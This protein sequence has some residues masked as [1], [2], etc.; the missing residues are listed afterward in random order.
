MIAYPAISVGVWQIILSRS[1]ISMR[2]DCLVLQVVVH[3]MSITQ[4][5]SALQCH[6]FPLPMSIR[7]FLFSDRSFPH[8]VWVKSGNMTKQFPTSDIYQRTGSTI[9]WASTA[10]IL[11]FDKSR[12]FSSWNNTP[13][14]W[15]ISVILLLD[16]RKNFRI[17]WVSFKLGTRWSFEW[18]IP[19]LSMCLQPRK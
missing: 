2:C 12:Y 3:V 13:Y 4:R 10:K 8:P 18:R 17:L 15:R 1:T 14:S 6:W 11:L 5:I 19:I 16:K 9:N 7:T